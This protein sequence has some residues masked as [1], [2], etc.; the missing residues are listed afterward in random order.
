MSAGNFER[1]IYETNLGLFFRILIQPETLTAVFDGNA[2]SAGAGPV[3]SGLPSVSVSRGRRS[4]GVNARLVRFTF[5]TTT[6]PGYQAG[7][8]LT[9]P[10]LTPSVFN[11]LEAGDT[12]TYTLEGTAY[13]ITI[14]GVT[15]ETIK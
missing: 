5:T 14:V 8:T 11:T 12:G 6:P 10:V 1:S 7:S 4:Y 9:L 2:N 15:P 13:D 3:P